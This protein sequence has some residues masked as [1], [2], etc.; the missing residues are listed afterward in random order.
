LVSEIKGKTTAWDFKNR[1][2][3]KT[4][5]HNRKEVRGGWI[6]L[7]NEKLH[8]IYSSSN[9]IRV[10]KSKSTKGGAVCCRNGNGREMH[11]RFEVKN[12][13]ERDYLEDLGVDWRIILK[14]LKKQVGWVV[15]I[16]L[17]DRNTCGSL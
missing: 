8:D 7:H 16:H 9:I 15:F 6:K 3:R 10:I 2:L 5:L 14:T 11:T 1:V 17:D 13:K 4:F 12:L